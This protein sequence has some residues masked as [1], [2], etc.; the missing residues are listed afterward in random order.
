MKFRKRAIVCGLI[1]FTVLISFM[2]FS[3]YSDG[4]VWEDRPNTLFYAV[5][6]VL[7]K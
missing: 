1:A 4:S 2:V 6:K 7:I 5:E 3:L